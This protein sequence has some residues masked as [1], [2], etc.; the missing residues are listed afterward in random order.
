[1]AGH[2]VSKGFHSFTWYQSRRRHGNHQNKAASRYEILT[3]WRL[4]CQRR[5]RSENA[6][7]NSNRPGS[8]ESGPISITMGIF[9]PVG[10]ISG[11]T[12]PNISI[13]IVFSSNRARP[14]PLLLLWTFSLR[15]VESDDPLG[16]LDML[17]VAA[18]VPAAI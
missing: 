9:G 16:D 1:M 10:S 12:G 17:A 11:P 8:A 6:R 3:F 5:L 15:R 7:S 14:G 2:F 13:V 18:P 4:P